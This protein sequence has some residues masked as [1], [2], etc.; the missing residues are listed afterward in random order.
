[1]ADW[2]NSSILNLLER[3][4]D[5]LALRQKV[6]ADNI[7]NVDTPGF[8]KSDLNFEQYLQA[9][10]DSR[11]DSRLPA[12]KDITY[13]HS[14]PVKARDF[15]EKDLATSFRNDGNNVDIDS[16]MTKLAQNNLHYDALTTM[17]IGHLSILKTVI[18]E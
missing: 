3:G 9:A 12:N 5:G 10:I 17:L 11:Q 1:M 4:L 2:L 15:V 14:W 16:E 6:L 8:K 13:N 7:A 18:K